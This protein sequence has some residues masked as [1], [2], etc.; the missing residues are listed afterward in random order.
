MTFET[1]QSHPKTYSRKTGVITAVL[2]L[3][4]L[5]LIFTGSNIRIG[6][7]MLRYIVALL[8]LLNVMFNSMRIYFDKTTT[9]F[10]L[11]IF[12]YGVSCIA[13]GFLSDFLTQLYY[14]YFI[15]FF[16]C[17]LSLLFLKRDSSFIKPI[18]YLILAIGALDVV[19]TYSQFIFKDDWYQPI[20]QFF[21]FPVW[22]VMEEAVDN[23]FARLEAMDMTLPGILGNGVYNGY[24]LSVCAVLS[25]VF[26]IRSK[27]ALFY[28]I[29]FFYILGS[30]VCQQR[31]PLFIS[32]F[33]IAMVSLRLFKEFSSRSRFVLYIFLSVGVVM[34]V[35]LL[36]NL[37]TLL[38][39][40]YSSTGLDATGR[41]TMVANA[42]D[43]IMSHPFIANPFELLAEKKHMPHNI[44]INAYVYGG[45]L[46]FIVI[47]LILFFQFKT[48]IKI[49]KNNVDRQN[50]YYYVFAWAWAAFTMNGLLHNRS[51]ITGDYMIWMIWGVM[52]AAP[53]LYSNKQ[54]K[55]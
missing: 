51:I 1:V 42:I 17:L 2:F 8:L 30:F 3:T 7:V 53:I 23:K 54:I 13:T 35:S 31:G 15:A 20:E 39:L 36:S 24:F 27:N 12:S 49:V 43:Y 9:L 25:M 50:A 10:L 34:A 18:T 11:F 41:D 32:L 55:V 26:V 6:G 5:F 16:A 29:P 52:L 4:F 21:R 28:I 40:R 33:V 37:S 47:L 44:F 22:D 48:F 45:I 14:T 19:V 46:S 38:G